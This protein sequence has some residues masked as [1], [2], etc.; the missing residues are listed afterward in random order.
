[1]SATDSLESLS[2]KQAA[3]YLSTLGYPISPSHLSNL[4][5]NNNAG[6]GPPFIRYGWRT[7]RYLRA[8]LKTWLEKRAERVE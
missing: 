6:K 8:D 4:A 7:V 1:M 5:S 2:R 3:V